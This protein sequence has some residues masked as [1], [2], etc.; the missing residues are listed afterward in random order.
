MSEAVHDQSAPASGAETRVLLIDDSK[1]MRKSALKM[2]G[3][4]FDVVVAEDGEQGW[5]MIQEDS[6]IHVVFTDLNMPKMNGYQLLE[7]VRTAQDEGI[8]NLPVI[9]VTGAEN[10]DEAKENALNQGATDFITKP[11]NSTDLKARAHA[12]ANYQRTTKALQET[13]TVDPLTGLA[14]QRSFKDQ[15]E[16]DLSFVTRHGH[17]IAVMLVEV[18]GFRELFLKIGR[19]GA[20]SL[21]QQIAKVLVKSVRK[22]DCVGRM[23]LAGFAISLPT[24]GGEGATKLAERICQSV[25]AFK[26]TLR[27]E[28]LAITVSIGLHVPA[29]STSLKADALL[30]KAEDC[31]RLATSAGGNRVQSLVDAAKAQAAAVAEAVSIDQLLAQ[32]QKGE[33]Q[34]VAAAL[35]QLLAQLK[36]LWNLLSAAQKTELR[37]QLGG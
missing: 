35:P 5:Q 31:L 24:A 34:P 13:A 10:D 6:R 14:N 30:E 33:T 26:A 32:L 25:A 18:D 3:G 11:F 36:P 20:D 17:D 19:K 27:G 22:E 1:V 12:H 23:G 7:M 2:L 4:D 15:F 29:M 9:V 21:V 28:N 8:R 37:Q 16:K